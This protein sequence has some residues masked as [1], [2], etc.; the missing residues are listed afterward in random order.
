MRC[1]FLEHMTTSGY[2]LV[3]SVWQPG[4]F[5]TSN[6]KGRLTIKEASHPQ[7]HHRHH[8][9]LQF[10]KLSSSLSTIGPMMED[11]GASDGVD[12]ARTVPS[13]GEAGH[14]MPDQS[15]MHD[16]AKTVLLNRVEV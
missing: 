15:L 10:A 16:I 3:E 1:R 6:H 4:S 9:C 13:R 14:E 7:H 2:T 5:L 12:S 11:C 8:K